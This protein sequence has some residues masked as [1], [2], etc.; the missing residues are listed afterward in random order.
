[1]ARDWPRAQDDARLVTV[2]LPGR[3]RTHA[4]LRCR[5]PS[6]RLKSIRRRRPA[7]IANAAI[8]ITEAGN[9]GPVPPPRLQPCPWAA[10]LVPPIA[11]V[12]A[13]PVVEPAPAPPEVG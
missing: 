4:R 9:S 13:W 11:L 8:A 7:A 10:P 3:T 1:N 5:A 12:P 6:V 2:G